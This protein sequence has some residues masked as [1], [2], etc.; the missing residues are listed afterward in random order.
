MGLKFIDLFAGVGGIR[1]GL[2][3]IGAHCVMTSEIDKYARQTYQAY[4]SEDPSHVWN[5]DI[6]QIHPEDVPDHDILAGGFPCQPFSIAGVSKKNSLGRAHGF[7]DPTKGTLFF[8]IKEIL[9]AKRPRAFL[10]ENVK[11]LRGHD[12]GRTWRVIE[13]A[14]NEIG[15]VFTSNILDAADVVPQH[16]ERVFIIGFDREYFDLDQ[17]EYDFTAFWEQVAANMERERERER[18]RYRAKDDWPRVRYI[19]D[20]KVD[21]RY[22][23]SDGLWEYLKEYKA[24]HRAKGNGFGYSLFDGSESYTRTLSARYYKDGSEVLI[25]HAGFERPRRLTPAECAR[26]QGFPKDFVEM[27]LRENSPVSDSQAYKQFGNSVCVPVI[28]SIAGAMLEVLEGRI[29][30]D[31]SQE[32]YQICLV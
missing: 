27:F 32:N 17:P 20:K 12:K 5:E 18:L 24:K 28:G 11:N 6:T 31:V 13:H 1:L 4:F 3:R 22:Q 10:L 14:L 7:N 25:N 8:N 30:F 23:L 2:E 29:P 21:E 15:Y 19:L 9:A 26:L 16:R